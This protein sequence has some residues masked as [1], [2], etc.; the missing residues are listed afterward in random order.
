M[1]TE[2]R[3]ILFTDIVGYSKMMSNDEKL[4]LALLSEHDEI[5]LNAIQGAGG[6]VIKN[7]GD[8]FF[9]EFDSPSDAVD[10]CIDF[11]TT[12]QDRNKLKEKKEQ[13]WVRAGLHS[14]EVLRR[15]GDLFG[16]D[17]NVCARLESIA[18]EGG[19]VASQ[20]LLSRIGDSSFYQREIGYL[21]LKNIND[22]VQTFRIYTDK[23]DYQSQSQGQLFEYYE[24]RGVP[25]VDIDSYQ[26]S[27]IFSTAFLYP[28]DLSQKQ[29]SLCYGLVEGLVS[30]FQ[31]IDRVRTPSVADISK[32]KDTDLELSKVA[33]ILQVES[34]IESTV[35]SDSKGVVISMRMYDSHSGGYSWSGEWRQS[36]SDLRLIRGEIIRDLLSHYD[37]QTPD[38]ILK[39]LER[40]FTSDADA[41]QCYYDAMQLVNRAHDVSDL[42]G[43]RDL[44]LKALE[45]DEK[46][47]EARAQLG[48]TYSKLGYSED[49]EREFDLAMEVAKNDKYEQSQAFVYNLLGI[50]NK[51]WYKDKKAIRYFE[52]ALELQVKIEDKLAQAKTLNS[53]ASAYSNISEVDKAQKLLERSIEIRKDLEESASLSYPYA[54]M[55]NIAFSRNDYSQAIRYFKRALALFRKQG[56]EYFV[57]R[58]ELQLSECFIRVGDYNQAKSYL[59]AARPM[60]L[61]FD[62][63]INVGW[64]HYLDAQIKMHRSQYQQA[65]EN[66]KK[67][68]SIYLQYGELIELSIE[69]TQYL[70][71]S[72][73]EVGDLESAGVEAQNLQKLNKRIQEK[74]KLLFKD[75]YLAYYQSCQGD[76][77]ASGIDALVDRFDALEADMNIVANLELWL[78]CRCYFNLGRKDRAKKLQKKI[79]KQIEIDSRSCSDVN[80]QK[81]NQNNGLH[82]Q[83]AAP[84]LAYHETHKKPE[85]HKCKSCG[86]TPDSG[87]KFCPSCGDKI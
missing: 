70:V 13:I 87:F 74:D 12:L 60:C 2:R 23:A 34:V 26:T 30:D 20:N 65:I 25:I 80:D 42:E 45:C 7:I 11:Q 44:F 33:Q 67:A 50:V 8:A 9:A 52:R 72:Y 10:A 15:D 53:L 84:L 6:N 85:A 59:D 61:E 5:L 54:T 56:N 71:L 22:P 36:A 38:Q 81:S 58:N 79:A 82:Q 68:N 75:I 49:A 3:A 48:V 18:P 39:Y 83:I 51:G 1:G 73:T 47:V 24:N 63:A 31:K 55:A 41:M 19:V 62:E 29:D 78:L 66:L 14:G 57:N 21:K 4:A 64:L 37:M 32:L 77:D 35:S 40:E 28:Q 46:F 17:I 86:F 27:D 76:A 43:A 69:V 16:H